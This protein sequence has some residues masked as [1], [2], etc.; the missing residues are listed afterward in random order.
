MDLLAGHELVN[1]NGSRVLANHALK[2]KS[3]I[4]FYFS[5]HWCPPCRQFTPVLARAFTDSRV[6]EGSQVEVVF[7]SSDRSEAAQQEYMKEAHGDWLAVPFGDPLVDQ[8]SSRFSVRG[9]P[10]LKVVGRDGSEIS[11]NARDEVMAIGKEAFVQWQKLAPAAIDT[12]S[13][14]LLRSNDPK[15]MAEAVNILKRLLENIVKDPHNIK[16]RAVNLGNKTIA[17]KLLPASGAFEVLF[18]VGFEEDTDKLLLPLASSIQTVEAFL[19]AI[20]KL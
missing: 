2:G 10:A 11:A 17:D 13:V 3:V 18:S 20:S 14:E 19:E 6:G 9:I 7:V 4:A 1:K 12:S 16:Y 8:L 5:A 15:V